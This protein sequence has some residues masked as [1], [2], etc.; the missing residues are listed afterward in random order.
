[1]E[2]L[3]L[4]WLVNTHNNLNFLSMQTVSIQYWIC[5]YSKCNQMRH[6]MF[7][8]VA[9]YRVIILHFDLNGGYNQFYPYAIYH[10]A[11]FVNCN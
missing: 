10:L 1:M 4:D 11:P 2:N 6:T 5:C 7:S 8:K 9:I 3:E